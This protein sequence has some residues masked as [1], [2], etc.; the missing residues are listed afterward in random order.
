MHHDWERDE[1]QRKPGPVDINTEELAAGCYYSSG[2]MREKEKDRDGSR[3]GD[4]PL[5]DL[6]PF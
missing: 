6:L 5:K 1:H 4:V 3:V 2:E